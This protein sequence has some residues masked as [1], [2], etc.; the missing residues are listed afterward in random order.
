MGAF[1]LFA[2][3][4]KKV[5][6]GPEPTALSGTAEGVR[7]AMPVR[8][9]AS[10]VALTSS[11]DPAP[12]KYDYCQELKRKI[13]PLEELKKTQ[14]VSERFINV[15]KRVNGSIFRLRYFHKEHAEGE[16]PTYLLYIEDP[17]QEAHLME[18]SS[19][20]KGP[21]YLRIERAQGEVLYIEKG[22]NV[23]EEETLFLHFINSELKGLQGTIPE[24]DAKAFIDCRF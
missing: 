17:E 22:V 12:L 8:S 18:I 15:H 24:L 7:A 4:K 19:Y 11:H 9:P 13:P 10:S 16:T 21:E 2:P 3:N 23:G 6:S 5:F 1:I 20:Q 14:V